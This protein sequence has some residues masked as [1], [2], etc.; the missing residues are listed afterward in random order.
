VLRKHFPARI[1]SRICDVDTSFSE[2]VVGRL[3]LF[4]GADQRHLT[5]AAGNQLGGS[6][7]DPL[8]VSFGKHDSTTN[9]RS[10]RFEPFKKP[11]SSSPAAIVTQEAS[12]QSG[13]NDLQKGLCGLSQRLEQACTSHLT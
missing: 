9:G 6:F 12:P 13:R 10:S 2:L 3:P 11:H 4:P 1:S 8:I 5:P 7:D